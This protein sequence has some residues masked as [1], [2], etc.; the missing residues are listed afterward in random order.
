MKTMRSGFTL[1][2]ML[3][4]IGIIGILIV[5]LVPQVKKAQVAGKEAAIKAQCANIEAS[6]ANYYQTKT[7]GYPAAAIDVMAPWGDYGLGDPVIFAGGTGG[8]FGSSPNRLV[9]GVLGGVGHANVSSTPVFQQIKAVKDTALGTSANNTP[10]Y[11][12]SLLVADAVQEYPANPFL[13]STA[14]GERARM[15]NV[16]RF[17]LNLASFDP[18]SAANGWGSANSYSVGL[19]AAAGGTVAGGSATTDPQDPSRVF[20]TGHFPLGLPVSGYQPA[21]YSNACSFGTGPNDYFAPGDFA[22]IP[23]FKGGNFGNSGATLQDERYAWGTSA[24]GYLFFGYGDKNNKAEN[25]EDDKREFV[26]NGL[27]GYG[28]AGVD[29]RYEAVALQCFEGAIYFSKKF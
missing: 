28:N 16:F 22:Y 21:S 13:T 3:V 23:V 1:V 12:D 17:A 19:Y 11:F 2:E 7:T 18:N 9:A 27:P 6:L 29:T 25:F 15:R 14:T 24:S 26:A 5:A 4:V 20:I 10:R 8:T